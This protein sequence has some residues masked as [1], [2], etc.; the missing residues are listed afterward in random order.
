MILVPEDSGR[1]CNPSDT[2]S[3]EAIVSNAHEE[4]LMDPAAEAKS[5]GS[6]IKGEAGA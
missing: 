1:E 2:P 5:F 6:K 3:K 4:A